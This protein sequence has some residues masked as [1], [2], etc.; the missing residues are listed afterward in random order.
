MFLPF[1]QPRGDG[2]AAAGGGASSLAGYLSV[3]AAWPP[4]PGAHWSKPA[5][6]AARL[7][8]GHGKGSSVSVSKAIRRRVTPVC[9]L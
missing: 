9:K 4:S 5:V 1:R 8:L 7:Q 2:P 6:A 3:L